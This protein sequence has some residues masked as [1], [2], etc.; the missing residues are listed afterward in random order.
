VGSRARDL[1]LVQLSRLPAIT[2]RRRRIASYYDEAIPINHSMSD[3]EAEAVAEA[4]AALP[5]NG[6]TAV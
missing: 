4:V 2:E 1:G 3:G 6:G 5:R